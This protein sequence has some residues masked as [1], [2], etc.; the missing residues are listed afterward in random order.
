MMQTGELFAAAAAIHPDAVVVVLVVE[1]AVH[2]KIEGCDTLLDM[3]GDLNSPHPAMKILDDSSTLGY[4]YSSRGFPYL[5]DNSLWHF[6]CPCIVSLILEMMGHKV[7][8]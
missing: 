5:D 4:R 8:S 2:D 3:I 7:V 1:E 6:T